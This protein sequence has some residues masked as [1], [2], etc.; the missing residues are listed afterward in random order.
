MLKQQITTNYNFQKI[1]EIL[2]RASVKLLTLNPQK[3]FMTSFVELGNLIT[4]ATTDSQI[5][6]TV[7]NTLEIIVSAQMRNF[8]DNIFW[9]FDFMVS[10]M[11]RQALAEKDGAIA[12]LEKFADKMVSLNEIFGIQGEIKFRYVHDFIYGFDWARWV[13]R[14]LKTLGYVE[15]FSLVILDYLLNRSDEIALRI[16]QNHCQHYKLCVKGYRNA[17]GFSREP[18]NEYRLLTNLAQKRLIPVPAWSWYGV[19]TWNQPFDN[20]RQEVALELNIKSQKH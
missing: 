18:E 8:P 6:T 20:L 9:D 3:R 14:N 16:H 17:F 10:G 19:P 1:D 13:Q 11:L 15:P 2:E 5:I 7:I 4:E 12:Y